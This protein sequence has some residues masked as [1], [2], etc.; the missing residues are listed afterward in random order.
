M[1]L[2]DGSEGEGGGQIVR[3]SLSLAL[4][5]G[6]PVRIDNIRAKRTKP[7]LM[8]QHLTAVL[9]AAE[10]GRA[11]LKGAALGSSRLTFVPKQKVEGGNFKFR[12]GT[13]GSTML[14]L[15]TVLPPL[16]LAREP[17]QIILEG[18]THN[19]LAPPFEFV[20]RSFAPLIAKMG[21]TIDLKLIRPGF[22]PAGGGRCE[23]SIKPATSLG[24]LTL[25][26]RG[27]LQSQHARAMV[28]NLPLK[29]AERECLRV[30]QSLNWEARCGHA[31]AWEQ[32]H[33]PG[34]AL[35]AELEFEHVT[36]VCSALG[37]RG[38]PADHVADEVVAAVT[39]YFS[40]DAPVGEYLAD[41]L[42]L[43]LG[44][45]AH[46]GTGGGAFR[47]G[48]LSEHS[49]TH[50]NLL[51]QFLHINIETKDAGGGSVIVEVQR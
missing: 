34:N 23:V 40:T 32:S 41:Q 50:I 47:T 21:A 4:M 12:I 3:S 46:F 2:I 10:L 26:E 18:G 14:V 30:T 7:G 27:K 42:L 38:K 9:A 36:E 35:F 45:G 33:S 6:T 1:L 8:R 22:F 24:P 15:Q 31:G 28:A 20:Q 5:T 25:L 13:A 39:R 17:S 11:E 29:I 48:P 19:P 49:L 44:L 37:E 43:P 51:Q 16:L